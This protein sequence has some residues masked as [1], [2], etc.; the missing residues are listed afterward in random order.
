VPVDDE[1]AAK[2]AKALLAH[3]EHSSSGPAMPEVNMVY[4]ISAI[5]HYCFIPRDITGLFIM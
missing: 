5:S 1:A 2:M 3:I 4:H